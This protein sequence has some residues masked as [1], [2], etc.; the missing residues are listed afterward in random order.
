MEARKEDAVVALLMVDVW[1]RY[2]SVVPLKPR[3]TQTVGN[4]L[5]KF[6]NEIDR[7]ERT[8]L[9]GDNEPVLAAGMQ[10]CQSARQRLGLETILTWNRAYEKSCTSVAER[11]VQTIRE[12]QKTLICN[13]ETRFKL[14]S[15]LYMQ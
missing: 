10:F 7:V 8:E 3:N 15:Q 11:F 6:F 14:Q 4:A 2:V 1:S 13:L 5:G 12:L 9:A